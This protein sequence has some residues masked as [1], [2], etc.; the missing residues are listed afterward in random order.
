MM[1]ISKKKKNKNEKETAKT[2]PIKKYLSG[3]TF[4][5][6]GFTLLGISLIS[7]TCVHL[8]CGS[9]FVQFFNIQGDKNSLVVN[10]G[11]SASPAS[12]NQTENSLKDCYE[13]K[14][15][16]F[17]VF[18]KLTKAELEIVKSFCAD[19]FKP[20]SEQ[21]HKVLKIT[22]EESAEGKGN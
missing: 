21:F 1:G 11:S 2:S 12:E 18:E 3:L 4:K 7:F 9:A 15:P 22:I 10:D 19:Y 5:V 13:K 17:P 20:Q 6:F 14:G 8:Q 16:K